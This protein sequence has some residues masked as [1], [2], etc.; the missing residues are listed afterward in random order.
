MQ[1]RVSNRIIET[2]I[3]SKTSKQEENFLFLKNFLTRKNNR[4]IVGRK[5]AINENYNVGKQLKNYYGDD[6]DN[7]IIIWIKPRK[8]GVLKTVFVRSQTV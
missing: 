7:E 6:D 3:E 2:L 8:I 1:L 4:H 5:R